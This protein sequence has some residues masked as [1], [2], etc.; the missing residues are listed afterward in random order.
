MHFDSSAPI[1]KLPGTTTSEDMYRHLAGIT[2]QIIMFVDLNGK[3]LEA[4]KAAVNA[5]GY[6]YEELCDLNIT[7]LRADF[8]NV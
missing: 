2:D 8:K 3:I 4:N 1:E 6:T 7:D 5:Y